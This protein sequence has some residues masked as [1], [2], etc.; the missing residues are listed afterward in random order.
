VAGL[1]P[2]VLAAA[3][4]A[5]AGLHPKVREGVGVEWSFSR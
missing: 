5:A 4:C 1:A 2:R 3:L